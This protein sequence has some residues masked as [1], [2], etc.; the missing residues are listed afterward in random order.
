MELIAIVMIVTLSAGL[1]LAAAH[2]VLWALFSVL[3][4]PARLRKPANPPHLK[5]ANPA[6]L[7]DTDVHETE[8]RSFTVRAPAA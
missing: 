5:P 7:K 6:H 8:T 1:G 4:R 3:M 2:A